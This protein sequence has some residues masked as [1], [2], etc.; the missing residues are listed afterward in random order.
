MFVEILAGEH[1]RK[2]LNWLDLGLLLLLLLLLVLR[3]VVM[4]RELPEHGTV[5]DEGDQPP[6]LEKKICAKIY[7]LYFYVD[8]TYF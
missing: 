1:L 8:P 3:V 2:K 5:S 7:L 6:Y 4:S